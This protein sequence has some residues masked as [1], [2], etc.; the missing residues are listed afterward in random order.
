MTPFAY[1]RAGDA[2]TALGLISQP[3]TFLAGGT[4]LVDLMHENIEQPDMVIDITG[5]GGLFRVDHAGSGD[6]Y[7]AM[8]RRRAG[9]ESVDVEASAPMPV[10]AMK[11]RARK[12]CLACAIVPKKKGAPAADSPAISTS[13]RT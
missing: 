2:P 1:S 7:S 5:L 6:T 3:H 13:R 9:K 10:E 4:N 12:L 8:L 11:Y